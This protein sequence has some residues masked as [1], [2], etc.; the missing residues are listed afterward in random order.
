MFSLKAKRSKIAGHFKN[1]Q[2]NRIYIYQENDIKKSCENCKD[3][4]GKWEK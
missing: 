2:L 4:Y 3:I 1:T